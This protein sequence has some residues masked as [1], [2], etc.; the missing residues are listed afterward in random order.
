MTD[1][2]QDAPCSIP[3]LTTYFF[4]CYLLYS[5]L[6]ERLL[7]CLRYY[8]LDAVV[9][10]R[11]DLYHCHTVGKYHAVQMPQRSSI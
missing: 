2:L 4:S 6:C 3:N 9:E 5:V 8:T 11:F 7:H 1:D 10:Y